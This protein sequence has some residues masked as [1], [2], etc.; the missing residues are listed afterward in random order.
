MKR[1]TQLTGVVIY[2]N[3]SGYA[4]ARM[5]W[6]PFTNKFPKVF[7][8]AQRV[9]DVVNAVRWARENDVPIRMRGGRHALAQ[10]FSQVDC[11]IVIDVSDMQ[12]VKLDKERG[13]ATVQTGIRVGALV[14]MLANEGILAPFGDSSTVGIAGITPGGGI[15][16][17]Q[18][19]VGL[20]CDNLLG[21]TLVDAD[22]RII[23]F[24]EKKNSDLLWAMR[25]GGG[26]NFGIATSYTFRI[27]PAPD[28]V[29]IF[30]I[31]WPWEQV[32]E[33]IDAWQ[34]W[35]PYV[36]TRLGT[37]LEAFSK[38]NGLLH[39]SGIFLGSKKELIHL[40]KPLLAVGTPK[41]VLVDEVSL[42]EAI[43]FWEPVESI[44]D[45][46]YTKWS[47][48][49][50]E[51][52]VPAQGLKAIRSFLEKATGSEAN[53][54]FLNSGGAMNRVSPQDTAFFWRNT[55]Y[56]MEWNASWTKDCETRRNI[57]LVEEARKR[58]NPFVVGS[59]VNV[60]D[61]LIENYGR[62]YYAENFKRLRK[63]K[64]KY[65]PDNVFRFAQSIPPAINLDYGSRT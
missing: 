36:D 60:P 63:I 55:K 40:I 65:D 35:S 52:T 44:F 58:L 18:R 11:G 64:A 33:V 47:S 3:D 19:S 28:Q 57:A 9:E 42:L 38:T 53:F 2:P 46:Q 62:E 1:G 23:C 25:G 7:V 26:G 45:D 56:Y 17:I 34:N 6:N 22:G 15:T 12:G 48:A 27:H 21:G 32:E 16:A 41:K 31:V 54:F 13:V 24:N 30:D 50:V 61:L 10:D 4:L 59:Y 39:S 29:G 8:F 37:I 14:R 20:I 43:E 49:W 5:N 51:R